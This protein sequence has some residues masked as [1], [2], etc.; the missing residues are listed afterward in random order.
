M[1]GVLFFTFNDLQCLLFLYRHCFQE[2]RQ[3]CC[4]DLSMRR[5]REGSIRTDSWRE[6][7]RRG[8]RREEERRGERKGGKVRGWVRGRKGG[9]VRGREGRREGRRDDKYIGERERER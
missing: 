4:C 6:E 2:A 7:V 5:V 1:E 8:K 9:N 3:Q